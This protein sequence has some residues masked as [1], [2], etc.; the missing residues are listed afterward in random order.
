LQLD[1]ARRWSILAGI[2]VV[3]RRFG[4][5]VVFGLLA[6]AIVVVPVASIMAD[7]SAATYH[8]ARK[9]SHFT[10]KV[11]DDLSGGWTTYLRGALAD[12]N[13]NDTVTLDKVSSE[14]NPQGYRPVS[15]RVEVCNWPYGT[16]TKWL[17]LTRL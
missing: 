7:T 15:G 11:G 14:T 8:W 17:G 4:E 9:R 13:K 12:W 1:P 6:M 5:L 10:L 2:L 16:Q 3:I